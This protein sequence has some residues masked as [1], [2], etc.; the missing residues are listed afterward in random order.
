MTGWFTEDFTLAELRTLRAIERIPHLRPANTALT[1]IRKFSVNSSARPSVMNTKPIPKT[2]AKSP[3]TTRPVPAQSV[4]PEPFR[5]V[6]SGSR[7]SA[8]TTATAAKTMLT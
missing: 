7:T 4:R 5:A 8:P 1:G 6:R 3:E 2:S